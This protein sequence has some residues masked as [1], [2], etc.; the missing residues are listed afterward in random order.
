MHY[1]VS[2]S[3]LL[4][5]PSLQLAWAPHIL[6]FSRLLKAQVDIDY[7]LDKGAMRSHAKYSSPLFGEVRA[8]SPRPFGQHSENGEHC[9]DMQCGFVDSRLRNRS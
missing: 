3:G 6:L 9:F 8:S 2:S 4:T 1:A 7:V 5:L